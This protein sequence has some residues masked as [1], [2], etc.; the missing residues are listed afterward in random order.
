MARAFS[1]ATAEQ[2][3]S[4][5]DAVLASRRPADID[6][7]S[8]FVDV[9]DDQAEAA[10]RLAVDFGLLSED[11]GVFAV[12]SPLC[13]FLATPSETHK[14]AVLRILLESYEPFV[15]FRERLQITNASS[16]AQETKV[17]LDLDAHREG[18]K[19]TLI[20]LGTYS[21]ALLTEGGGHYRLGN[22][23]EPNPLE[24]LAA[25]AADL[26]AAE[27][28][29]REHIGA[30]VAAVASRVDVIVPLAEA[31]LRARGND[32]RG[33]V[34]SAGN[35]VESYVA[36]LAG[37]VG[38]GLAGATG[39]NAIIDRLDQANT[40]PKKLVFVGKYLGHVRNAADH[41]VDPDVGASWLIQSS[42]GTEYV[43][44]AC[45][46]LRST[47]ARELGRPPQV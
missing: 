47:R 33:A 3:V 30:D 22:P 19:D 8:G 29:V 11:Q 46:F 12:S 23:S 39:I 21:G 45:S 5:V 40:L 32:G 9:P 14:A 17:V 25:G 43:F 31:L 28:R 18:I 7:V 20:S 1:P 24:T 4:V 15:V 2:V 35:A 42:T 36:D 41:G 38:V 44:V 34:V 27:V 26:A 6:Y 37:R 13:E 16:A 10:L